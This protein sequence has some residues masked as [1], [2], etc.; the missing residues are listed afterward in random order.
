L[1]TNRFLE[2]DERK[3]C[4]FVGH[5]L[6]SILY[7]YVI[8]RSQIVKVNQNPVSISCSGSSDHSM[9]GEAYPVVFFSKWTFLWQSMMATFDSG[10]LTSHIHG[11]TQLDI[12]FAVTLHRESGTG[13]LLA[14]A[15]WDQ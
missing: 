7:E 14:G 5:G 13:R 2:R 4:R 10:T 1:S 6:A 12:V 9:H 11:V 3:M 8:V 15:S